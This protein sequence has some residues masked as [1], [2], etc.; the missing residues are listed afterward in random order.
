MSIT[1]TVPVKVPE[2]LS[3]LELDAGGK[4]IEN[5]G[6]GDTPDDAM[7]RSE[8]TE[9][10]GVYG[11]TPTGL[12]ADRPAP[13]IVDRF[14][15]STDTLVL[16]RD[17]GVAWVEV[18]RGEAAI[19]LVQ[20]AERAHSSLIGIGPSDH[21]IRYTDA[22]AQAQAAALIAIHAAIAAAHHTKTTAAAE[23][24]SGT[25]PV[26]RGGT[27]LSTIALGGILYA[28]A[29]DVLS[30]LAPTAANQVLRSTAANALQF[31]A[32]LAADIPNLDASKITTGQLPLARL[33]DAVCSETEAD[34]KV[35]T[36]NGLASP[37]AAATAIGGKTLGL[38]DG[39]I[40]VLPTATERQA[41]VR[42][43]TGWVAGDP[44]PKSSDWKGSF[45][46]DTSEYTTNEQDVSA[47]FSTNLALT[48]RRKYSVKLDL[49]AVE[50]DASFDELYL[51]VKEKINPASYVP[52]D[53]KTVTKADIAATAESGIP[54]IVPATSENI[55]ITMQMKTALA[56]DAI[57]YY[58]VVKEH[59]E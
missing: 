32:L 16:E 50:A 19:R 9:D 5:L 2:K 22:E 15:F 36:H 4:M 14:Y 1:G 49:T 55:Q 23:I 42:G 35:S 54:I 47:L 43:P 26:V 20:L 10:Y 48:T 21:H 8:K 12:A 40:A 7:R 46:W 3:E 51:A 24:T 38:A 41:L 13:G 59:L 33:V 53:R 34:G 56:E 11:L 52:I 37:H 27:G 39:N 29:L 17:T 58:A 45:N 18:V 44:I 30:R 57:I 28:S 6:L 25:F 31:A